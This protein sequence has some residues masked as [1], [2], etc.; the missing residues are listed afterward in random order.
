M[1][2]S[3]L[4]GHPTTPAVTGGHERALVPLLVLLLI[5]VV[6]GAF[7]DVLVL[8]CLALG[9]VKNRPDRLLVRGV[10]GGNVEELLGGSRALTS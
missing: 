8:L 5:G 9:V 7:A 1:I 3:A 10:A 4:R 2:Q 6:G